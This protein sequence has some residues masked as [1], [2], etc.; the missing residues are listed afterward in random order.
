MSFTFI[1][2]DYNL[3][4]II[5][6]IKVFWRLKKKLALIQFKPDEKND[7]HFHVCLWQHWN[8]S[9]EFFFSSWDDQKLI[10]GH[11]NP[12]IIIKINNNRKE[13]NRTIYPIVSIRIFFFISHFIKWFHVCLIIQYSIY[14]VDRFCLFLINKMKFLFDVCL[15]GVCVCVCA[16][17]SQEKKS[18]NWTSQQHVVINSIKIER[19]RRRRK[20]QK[21]NKVTSIIRISWSNCD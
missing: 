4:V 19:R 12:W 21:Q 9:W 13:M 3:D 11:I 7:H 1:D 20:S 17:Y 6:I 2:D 10:H 16:K 15:V 18:S 14:W 5:I 8:L